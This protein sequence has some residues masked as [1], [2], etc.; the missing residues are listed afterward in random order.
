MVAFPRSQ[1]PAPPVLTASPTHARR[2]LSQN[3]G[4]AAPRHR[5]PF[6][7]RCPSAAV[8][9]ATR[10][11][12][13]RAM[14]SPSL[15]HSVFGPRRRREPVSATLCVC[16]SVCFYKGHVHLRI[17]LLK[18]NRFTKFDVWPH[19]LAL[20][21]KAAGTHEAFLPLGKSTVQLFRL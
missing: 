17:S 3:C 13:E 10:P 4:R 16:L 19:V 8:G 14:A 6:P 5:E 2:P 1:P 9:G 18:I 15:P 11:S 21:H 7:P 12:A 20:H